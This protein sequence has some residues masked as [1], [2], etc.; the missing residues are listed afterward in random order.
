MYYT[1]VL[2]LYGTSCPPF[3]ELLWAL[4]GQ[5]ETIVDRFENNYQL[6]MCLATSNGDIRVA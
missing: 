4:C 6:A 5:R 1:L 3:Q 2:C